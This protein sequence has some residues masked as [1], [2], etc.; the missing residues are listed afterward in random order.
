[1]LEE[2]C[3]SPH[4]LG[5]WQLQDLEICDG[6]IDYFEHHQGQQRPGVTGSGYLRLDVKDS[7]DMR[8]KPLQILDDNSEVAK[9]YFET[10]FYFYGDYIKQWPFLEGLFD[11]LDIGPFNLQRY[12]PGQPFR[13][14]HTERAGLSSLHRMF[15]FMTYLNDVEEGGETCFSHYGLEIKP[16]KGLTLLWP[17]EWTHAH[18]GNPVIKGCKYIITGWLHFH[19]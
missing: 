16:Q 4:F 1:M 3:S 7:V 8:I 9:R 19:K 18:C 2:P 14:V 17:A 15:V 5:S 11:S 13:K 6:L 12:M 10:L